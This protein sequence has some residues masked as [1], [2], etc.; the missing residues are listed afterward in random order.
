MFRCNL[1]IHSGVP[2]ALMPYLFCQGSPFATI[3]DVK[4]GYMSQLIVAPH[5]VEV[6]FAAG[7]FVQD[8]WM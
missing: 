5:N 7:G 2:C 6:L 4:V 1:F 3:H 8:S